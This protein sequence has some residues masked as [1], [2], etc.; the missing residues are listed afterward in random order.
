MFIEVLI[1]ILDMKTVVGVES[2]E[3]RYLPRKLPGRGVS[4]S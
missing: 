1:D 2:L 4:S 3:L